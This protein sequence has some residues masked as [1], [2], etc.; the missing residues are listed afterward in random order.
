MYREM[1]ITSKVW[2]V[3]AASM[4]SG[5]LYSIVTM[6]FETTKNRMAFQKPDPKTGLLPYRSTL[7][8][9]S[10]IASKEGILRLWSGFLPYY[11]RCGGHTVTMFMSME[12]L[13]SLL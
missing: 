5:L 1:G 11:L 4:S 12:F 6:P 7:Q 9:M 10:K 3:F 8:T 2:N 13:R